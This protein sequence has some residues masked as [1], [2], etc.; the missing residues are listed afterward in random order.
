MA[1]DMTQGSLLKVLVQFSLPLFLSGLLQELYSW[2][3][4]FMV[5]NVEG[6]LSLAAIGSTTPISNLIIMMITG[7]SLGIC[8]LSGQLYGS[9]EHS[10]LKK[11]LSSFSVVLSGVFLLAVI[12]GIIFM[13]PLLHLLQTPDAI[14]ANASSYLLII[15]LGIPFLVVYNVYSAVLRGMGD[16]KTS[17]WAIVI[18]SL[19]NILTDILFVVVLR[20]GV[21]GAAVSTVI[22]QVL[23][24]VFIVCYSTK[25]YTLMRFRIGKH[26]IDGKI[27]RRG[28]SLSLPTAIQSSVHSVGNLTL[29]NFMNGFGAQTVA[30][31]TA[32]YRV[33]GV[34][35]LPIINLGYGISTVVAQNT[36]AKNHQ[37]A[38]RG[39]FVGMGVMVVVATIL[40]VAVAPSGGNLV[41]MFGVT[42]ESAAIGKTFFSIIAPFYLLFG[43]ATAV[44]SFLEGVGDVVFTGIV[45]IAALGVRVLLT[46]TLSAQYG[47]SIIALAEGLSWAALL[48]MCLIRFVWK[49]RK[50]TSAAPQF[51]ENEM[52]YHG[53]QE[54]ATEVP[55]GQS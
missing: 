14:F 8:V 2:S 7:F 16:S 51:P 39:A 50:T 52:E 40:T 5:G 36:G 48:L 20:Y 15:L 3:D 21:I 11:V 41:S 30:A 18:S 49:H 22:A 25:K 32:A 31:I 17:F 43:I 38:K 33:D 37:R 46:Y 35:M 27:L 28:L 34:I 9:G 53:P 6:E 4:A 29:Q 44:R 26:C 1:K 12:A 24:A 42:E 55:D 13:K 19:I 54:A 47:N 23:M 45:S 10:E